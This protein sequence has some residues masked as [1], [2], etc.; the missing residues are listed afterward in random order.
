MTT[1]DHSRFQTEDAEDD[2]APTHPC[3]AYALGVQVCGRDCCRRPPCFLEKQ[4]RLD[5]RRERLE[6]SQLTPLRQIKV[7]F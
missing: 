6:T 5:D 1:Q 3:T 4:S 7:F 2:K